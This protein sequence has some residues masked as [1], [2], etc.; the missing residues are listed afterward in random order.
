MGCDAD[1]SKWKQ[2]NENCHFWG[3]WYQ[4]EKIMSNCMK[5]WMTICLEKGTAISGIHV[6]GCKKHN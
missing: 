2:Y 4:I 5:V 1:R 3:Q 6:G